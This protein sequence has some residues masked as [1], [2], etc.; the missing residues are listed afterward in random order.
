MKR[1]VKADS[2]LEEGIKSFL[3]FGR[4]RNQ[5]AHIN[6]ATYPLEKTAEEIYKLYQSADFFISR[7]TQELQ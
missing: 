5:S 3:E 1:A 7:M 6:F 2:K 4:L